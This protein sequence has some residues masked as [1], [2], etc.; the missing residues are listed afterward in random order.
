MISA[1]AAGCRI[2]DIIRGRRNDMLKDFGEIE[3]H[4]IESGIKKRIVLAGAQDD[5]ALAALVRAKRKGFA[6][7]ILIGDE[8]KIRELLAGMEEPAEDYEI[9]NELREMTAARKAVKM[10]N[11]GKADLPMKGLMQTA[12]FLMAVQN[13]FGGL[14][15]EDGLL[16]EFTAFYWPEK[17]RIL[18]TGD[19]AINVAPTLEQKKIIAANLIDLARSFKCSPVRVAAVSVL[20]KPNPDIQSTMDAHELAQM[21]WGP[22]VIFEGPFALDNAL[23]EEAARHK[24][25]TGEVAGKADVL[26]MPDM[27]AGNVFHKCIHFFG[28]MPFASGT[29]G[30][31]CPIIMNSRTD[32]EDAKYYSVMTGVLRASL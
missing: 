25:I 27:H 31:R 28:H 2:F 26:L 12:S 9:V 4:L 1:A 11:E 6:Q 21:D 29:I 18:I 17:D 15:D 20:E 5:L 10:V 22:D 32:D 3:A 13:P 24:G 23:D 7:G 30:A 8:A 19:C 16:N 14:L